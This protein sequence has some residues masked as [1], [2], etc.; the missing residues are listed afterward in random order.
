MEWHISNRIQTLFLTSSQ[1]PE[2][3]LTISR[4]QTPA[5]K[6]HAKGSNP[7]YPILEFPANQDDRMDDGDQ[8][9]P[10]ISLPASATDWPIR[11]S[12]VVL[13]A[14]SDTLT[15][16]APRTRSPWQHATSERGLSG[17]GRARVWSIIL[18]AITAVTNKKGDI[19]PLCWR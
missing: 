16:H 12:R 4:T 9:H 10:L 2:P 6:V 19:T 15:G 3:N 8:R 1:E 7:N 11:P 18:E 17:G 5:M 14:T 13:A